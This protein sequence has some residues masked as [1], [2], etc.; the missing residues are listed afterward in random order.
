MAIIFS[1]CCK[2]INQKVS[3][4]KHRLWWWQELALSK[5]DLYSHKMPLL[6]FRVCL[7]IFNEMGLQ[8]ETRDRRILQHSTVYKT[9]IVVLPFAVTGLQHCSKKEI[10]NPALI[11]CHQNKPSNSKNAI[12]MKITK[13]SLES[14]GT[15]LHFRGE[16]FSASEYFVESSNVIHK[17]I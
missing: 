1:A 9:N 17:N 11:R 15:S 13:I 2:C 16:Y 4:S 5:L 14:C 6:V 3:S 12:K 10:L 7:C 8:F